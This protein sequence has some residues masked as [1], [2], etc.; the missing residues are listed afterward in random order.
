M[1]NRGSEY[2][3][4][5]DPDL[6]CMEH[7]E[8]LGPGTQIAVFTRLSLHIQTEL[9]IGVYAADGQRIHERY[10]TDRV[11][12]HLSQALEWGVRHAR[13]IAKGHEMRIRDMEF[14]A[15][16]VGDSVG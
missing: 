16:G 6:H 14:P 5:F 4:W 2:R 1:Q 9:F 13:I 8:I 7:H 10:H 11:G 12:D 15:A 3:E